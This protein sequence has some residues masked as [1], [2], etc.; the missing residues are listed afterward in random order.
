[1][2][3]ILIVNDSPMLTAI[4]KAVVQTQHQYQVIFT[5]GNGQ[6]CLDYLSK[7]SEL[8]SNSNSPDLILM[9]IHMPVMNGFQATKIIK[10]QFPKIKILI[11]TATVNRNNSIIFQCIAHGAIDYVRSPHLP[12]NPGKKVTQTQLQQGGRELLSK[13]STV[14][15]ISHSQYHK[16]I[17]NN[18][19]K[20]TGFNAKSPGA[21][22]Q[23]QQIISTAKHYSRE[24]RSS[25][26]INETISPQVVQKMTYLAIGCST[27]G[28]TTLA[29]LLKSLPANFPFTVIVCQHI[30]SD[31]VN[32]LVDWLAE[33]TGLE[34][35]LADKNMQPLPGKVYLAPGGDSNMI[36]STAGRIMLIDP[37]PEHIYKPNINV[38]FESMANNIAKRS[39][40]VV[41]TGM[42]DDGSKGLAALANAGAQVYVQSTSSAIIPSMPKNA[43]AALSDSV[44]AIR[45]LDPEN[46]GRIIG[47]S[48]H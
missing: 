39:M 38:L 13:M 25:N 7:S 29:I 45:S 40:G 5:A 21:N 22:Q 2:H 20:Q 41:L 9:D 17:E 44:Y 46:L 19:T 4:I 23:N 24:N 48:S 28:P 36:I 26:N 12:F 34:V 33:E 47:K 1:M 31:F 43:I 27:G 37:L 3:K 8:N 18:N 42:G 15:H 35:I 10:Q 6:E 14:L 16:T 30:D 11:T 32:G